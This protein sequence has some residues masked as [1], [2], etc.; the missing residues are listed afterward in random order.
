MSGSLKDS[1]A[2]VL[3]QLLVDINQ[4]V[5]PPQLGNAPWQAFYDNEPDLPD[6]VITVADSV[7]IDKGRSGNDRERV[8]YHGTQIRIRSTD[9]DVGFR[10]AQEIAIALD[11]VNQASVRVISGNGTTDYV[12]WTVIR[13]GKVLRMGKEVGVS[14]RR[15]F[16]INSVMVLY[17]VA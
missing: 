17:Q 9:H 7:G 4:A 8:G 10:K 2:A 1:P 11:K 12:V 6:D 15:L 16:S 13:Q 14:D 5:D 3:R